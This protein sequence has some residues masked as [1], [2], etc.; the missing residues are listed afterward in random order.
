MAEVE[1]EEAGQDACALRPGRQREV[2]TGSG[3]DFST[4]TEVPGLLVTREALAMMV[5]RYR[6]AR[7]LG[8]GKD[9]LEVA[10]GSG[11]G[12]GLV[13]AGARSLVAGDYSEPLLRA[14]R[15]HYGHRVPLIRLDAHRLPFRAA[16]F[17]VVVLFEAIYYLHEPAQFLREAARVLRPGGRVLI[18]SANPRWAGFHP[19]PYSVRYYDSE[20][21]RA[22]LHRSGFMPELYGA[23]AAD[24]GSRTAR[25]LAYA[26]RVAGRLHLIPR[27]M[28]GKV[29]LKRLVYRALVPV[30]AELEEG[31]AEGAPLV[32]LHGGEEARRFKVLYAVGTRAQDGAGQ[33]P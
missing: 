6:L 14:A 11:Q 9:V 28:A 18:C 7:S 24:A 8:E 31:I 5:T 15:R 29:W 10:C 3:H 12:L 2:V 17:D 22:L 16:S 1:R 13:A 20:D 21:L 26:K 33:G 23:F 30:P 32:R 25:W 4:V 19:S 27:T